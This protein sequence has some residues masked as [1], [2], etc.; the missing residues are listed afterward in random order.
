MSVSSIK[1]EIKAV[2]EKIQKFKYLKNDIEILKSRTGNAQESEL[3]FARKVYKQMLLENEDTSEGNFLIDLETEGKEY[4]GKFDKLKSEMETGKGGLSE[5]SGEA[6]T[7]IN[8]L[9][10]EKARLEAALREAEEAE[11]RAR[12][13]AVKA[14]FGA[15]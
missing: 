12:Q 4:T 2:K 13:A 14:F 11:R 1:A 6:Q 5:K 3:A 10:A 9:E 7:M 8:Q 15:K